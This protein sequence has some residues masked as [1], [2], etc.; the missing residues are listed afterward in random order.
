[1]VAACRILVAACKLLVVACRLDLVPGPGM[2]PGP[3]AFGAQ[4]LIHWTTREVPDPEL[5]WIFSFRKETH[6]DSLNFS[7]PGL[8]YNVYHC[9]KR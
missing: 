4:S 9:S 6:G 5:L 7:I 8:E 3:P 2:E 1:M